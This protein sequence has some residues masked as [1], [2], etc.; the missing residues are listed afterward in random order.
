M[1]FML[2]SL[3]SAVCLDG[4]TFCL[5]L[6]LH[7]TLDL[8]WLLF[9][10]KC[11]VL[12][13]KTIENVSLAALHKNMYR[14]TEKLHS[15]CFLYLIPSHHCPGKSCYFARW[16]RTGLNLCCCCIRCNNAHTHKYTQLKCIIKQ[17]LI[18]FLNHREDLESCVL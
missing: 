2:N 13:C 18:L 3:Y 4:D 6:A 14:W 12:E 16:C 1:L 11:S 17:G 10:L 5:V 8:K 7:S 15:L 9:H